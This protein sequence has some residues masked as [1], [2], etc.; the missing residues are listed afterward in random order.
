VLCSLRGDSREGT[1]AQ[2][3][4][5][6]RS[7]RIV[8]GRVELG[9]LDDALFGALAADGR[10]PYADLAATG[11]SET[12]GRAGRGRREDVHVVSPRHCCL[13]AGRGWAASLWDY[14]TESGTVDSTVSPSP[15]PSLPV[16]VDVDVGEAGGVTGPT[17]ARRGAKD[18]P[19]AMQANGMT[20]IR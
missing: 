16:D 8:G 12:A 2:L 4:R 11:W 3:A 7:G 5:L 6:P 14:E 13:S 9:D 20:G 18:R 19:A 1:D 17:A 10:A 15:S